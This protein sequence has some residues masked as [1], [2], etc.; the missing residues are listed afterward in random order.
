MHT[1]FL[2]PRLVR[3][4][5]IERARV[6]RR[7]PTG[8]EAALWE[9]LRAKRLGVKFRRQHAL[10]PYIVAFYAPALNLAVE[11][12]DAGE[13]DEFRLVE[14][15][16]HRVRLVRLFADDVLRDFPG[17]LAQIREAFEA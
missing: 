16:R 1:E 13:R 14:L 15:E 9:A 6:L 5:T 8:P 7:R 17:C 2:V 12:L 3:E 11:V 4:Q 10:G